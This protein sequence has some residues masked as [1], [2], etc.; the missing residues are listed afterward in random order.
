MPVR[1]VVLFRVHDAI[2]TEDV[3]AALSA[4]RALGTFDGLQEWRVELSS[5]RR[6]GRVIVE[7]AVLRDA[8]A[9]AAFRASPQHQAVAQRLSQM[10]DWLVGDYEQ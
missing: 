8:E 4:L 2:P 6:R 1:H 5:D 7:D 10:S 9:L 3:A